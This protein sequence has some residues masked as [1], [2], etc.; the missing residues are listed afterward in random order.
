MSYNILAQTLLEANPA[1]YRGC[2]RHAMAWEWRRENLLAEITHYAPSVLCL[3]EVDRE[4]ITSLA[5]RLRRFGFASPHYKGR[6]GENQRDGCAT[7][8]RAR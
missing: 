1:L 2:P 4:H 8:C 5:E 3:Q 7:F 6:V